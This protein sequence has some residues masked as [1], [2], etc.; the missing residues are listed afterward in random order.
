MKLTH[1]FYGFAAIILLAQTQSTEARTLTHLDNE[2][3][4][5][6]KEEYNVDSIDQINMRN[7]ALFTEYYLD[8]SDQYGPYPAKTISRS[9]TFRPSR[10][11]RRYPAFTPSITN[12]TAPGLA[13]TYI[14]PSMQKNIQVKNVYFNEPI[15]KRNKLPGITFYNNFSAFEGYTERW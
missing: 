13:R 2:E 9:I 8:R 4:E 1:I 7:K 10:D 12:Y 11:N 5:V 3:R 14:A 6:A 15:V